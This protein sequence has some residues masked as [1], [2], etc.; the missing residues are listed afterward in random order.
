MSD[1]GGDNNYSE[2]PSTLENYEDM[3][4]GVPP[5]HIFLR[6][7]CKRDCYPMLMLPMIALITFG[8]YWVFDTPGA[9]QTPLTQWF[10]ESNIVYSKS[11]NLLLYTVYSL[12]NTILALFGGFIIDR[13]TG[14]RMG[15][16]LFCS[17]VFVGQGLFLAGVL[18]KTY[19]ICVLGRFVFGL[20]GENL[21]VAQNT[22]TIR[23]FE[24]KSLALAFGVVVA[25]SRVGS[26]VNFAVTPILA[27]DI[28]VAVWFGLGMCALSLIFCALAALGDKLGQ[29]RI[30][31]TVIKKKRDEQLKKQEASAR[32]NSLK[33]NNLQDNENEASLV[34]VDSDEGLADEG[35]TDEL[36]KLRDIAQFP[37]AAW[38]LFLI[39]L[40]FYVA[41]LTFYTVASDIMQKTGRKYSD[42]TA[43]LF[44]SIPNFVAMFACPFFGWV[45]DRY[46]KALQWIALASFGFIVAHVAFLMLALGWIDISPV[47]IMLW[48]GF[49]YALGAS[50]IWPLIPRVVDSRLLGTAYGIMTSIQNAGLALFPFVIGKLQE[51][52][53][54]IEYNETFQYTLPITIF[55]ASA[56]FA[57]V[58]TLVLMVLDKRVHGGRLNSTPQERVLLDEKESDTKESKRRE[59][60]ML[61]DGK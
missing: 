48:I 22:F 38:L 47:F 32:L 57:L 33:A 53:W 26:S 15:A 43:S 30:D 42:D 40:F 18:M 58:L 34:Q 13:V 20:G 31:F 1:D 46:G 4:F 49:C 59:K 52:A 39:C 51:A 17:L 28:K 23:W 50:C 7:P 2:L 5:P 60:K 3:P 36:P 11:D 25:F 8:S 44:I 54:V 55:I 12:P 14:V 6:N 29:K 19:W 24:G 61:A 9:I 56:L 35:A 37:A 21:T 45:Q 27:R 10:N 41:V 16:L